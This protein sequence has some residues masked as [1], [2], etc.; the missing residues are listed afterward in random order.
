[1]WRSTISNLSHYLS[2]LQRCLIRKSISNISVEACLVS[3]WFF[4][5]CFGILLVINNSSKRKCNIILIIYKSAFISYITCILLSTVFFRE[6]NSD[7]GNHILINPM[8][9]Y[10]N[11]FKDMSCLSEILLNIILFFP[12]GF[13][14][15]RIIGNKRGSN[16][17][18]IVCFVGLILSLTIE[19]LQVSL[20]K[21][22]FEVADI[23][24]N[25]LGCV[26]GGIFSHRTI[27]E[28]YKDWDI[29]GLLD[30]LWFAML[31]PRIYMQ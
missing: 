27:V 5:L 14:L 19:T 1:M 15:L 17:L 30:I 9:L 10:Y 6:E 3:V 4:L 21:G 13:L 18:V 12:V 23:L 28:R 22:Y 26:L 20:G 16:Y 25:I 2:Y 29:Y 8:T 31:L 11:A 7:V 24:N